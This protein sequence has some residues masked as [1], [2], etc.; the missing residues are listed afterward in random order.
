MLPSELW[1]CDSY[2]DFLLKLFSAAAYH[3]YSK[4]VKIGWFT[5]YKIAAQDCH[6]SRFLGAVL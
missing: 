5:M 4:V 1:I 6:L 3:M 2:T